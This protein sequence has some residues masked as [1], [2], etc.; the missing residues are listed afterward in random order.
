MK[1]YLVGGAVRDKLLGLPVTE[2]DWV[3]VGATAADMH[4]DGFRQVGR[5]FPVFLHPETHEQYALARTERK[6]GPGYR[7]F[8]F[9]S[10]AQV[11]LEQDLL[12]RDLTVNAM[13]ETATGQLIDPYG[14]KEDIARR[15]LR[16]TSA[17]FVEDPLRVLRVARFAARFHHMNFTVAPETMA[18]MQQVVNAGELE[19]LT[20]ERVW[21][22]M[23]R[24]LVSN[25]PAR[26]IQVLRDCGALAIV[27]PE[28]DRLFKLAHHE[29]S[30]EG[31]AGGLTMQCLGE[32]RVLS[33]SHAVLYAVLVHDVAR[34]MNRRRNR[35]DGL[36]GGMRN[37]VAG[38]GM[39]NES[40]DPLGA[41]EQRLPVPRKCASLSRLVSRH[42]Q[43]LHQ[44]HTLE[45]ERLLDL[46]ESLNGFRWPERL[47]NILLACEAIARGRNP[48]LGEDYRPR[49][50]VR[51]L[52]KAL[53]S[54]D[55]GAI[56]KAAGVDGQQKPKQVLRQAR[57]AQLA[58]HGRLTAA[59]REP[60][61]G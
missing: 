13:A 52:H 30:S 37:E 34:D 18:L 14:G 8:D 7:G 44:V 33:D 19:T 45:P 10:S 17:A 20:P 53:L 46:L 58:R 4:A 39:G 24:A 15:M 48:Q 22:E 6:V 56:L 35:G 16:H 23:E 1:S 11:T 2:R 3:V 9:N 21:F 54:L 28:I 59:D 42:H 47:D 36:S 41:M 26:F 31:S 55:N 12:R 50:T 32:A 57:L 61:H 49:Q 43:T 51:A 38:T 27:L 5:D 40:A 60:G 25:S 29:Q